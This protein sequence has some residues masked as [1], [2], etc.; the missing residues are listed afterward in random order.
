MCIRDSGT[1]LRPPESRC[2]PRRGRGCS[3][4]RPGRGCGRRSPGSS[5]S[6]ASPWRAGTAGRPTAGPTTPPARCGSGPTST[7]PRRSRPWPTRPD[8]SCC[9][10]RPTSP[11]HLAAPAFLGPPL[12]P[13]PPQVLVPRPRSAA[14]S[15]RS[16]PNRWPIWSRLPTACRPTTTPSPTSPAGPPASTGPRVLAAGRAVLAGTQ[17]EATAAGAELA[18]GAQAGTERTA[19]ARAHAV[20]TLALAQPAA[21][22][23]AAAAAEVAALARL[24]ADA[25]AFYTAQLAAGSPDAARAAAL[26]TARAVPAAAVAGYELGYAPPG[27]TALVDHLRTRGYTDAQLLDAGVGLRTRRGTVVD[28]FRDRLMFPVRDPGGQRVVGFLGRALVEA[29]DTPRYLN[30]PATALYRK[31]EVLYGLGA[32]PTRQALAAGARPVLV[33]GMT[34]RRLPK[35]GTVGTD[36]RVLRTYVSIDEWY[37]AMDRAEK[38]GLSLSRYLRMLLARDQLDADG[39]PVWV[40]HTTS[41]D[42]LPGM[43]GSA[44]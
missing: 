26:L 42:E 33:E 24:H 2:P 39:R 17:P 29:E 34:E 30:S 23:P 3:P 31:G 20:A 43:E 6:G 21:A 12:L 1:S 15:G 38:A 25:A 7:P 40:P 16:R 4:A 14:A 37:D 11:C 32:E 22:D 36:L 5:A 41:S 8:T 9:T 18:A 27:W 35:P 44:A 10:T 19:A 28:R 13:A